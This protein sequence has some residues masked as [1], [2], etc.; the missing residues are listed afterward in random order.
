MAVVM[1]QKIRRFHTKF[2]INNIFIFWKT[3]ENI[4]WAQSTSLPT[5]MPKYAFQPTAAILLFCW[6][7]LKSCYRNW[8]YC[9]SHIDTWTVSI[10]TSSIDSVE[11]LLLSATKCSIMWREQ[12]FFKKKKT[13]TEEWTE[14]PASRKRDSWGKNGKH[15]LSSFQE[16]KWGQTSWSV[17]A[18]KYR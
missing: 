2:S 14:C 8:T 6:V 17:I 18:D 7:T 10:H 11:I 13:K 15:L 16:T 3:Y 12:F 1:V 5:T 9:V 4:F